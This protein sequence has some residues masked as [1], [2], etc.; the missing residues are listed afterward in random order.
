[1]Q[2]TTRS[3]RQ[4]TPQ[5][6]ATIKETPEL[7]SDRGRQR[8][9]STPQADDTNTTMTNMGGV[10]RSRRP[11]RRSTPSTKPSPLSPNSSRNKTML[12]DSQKIHIGFQHH[13]P[14][15]KPTS[16]V[17]HLNSHS[18]RKRTRKSTDYTE[19]PKKEKK[20]SY[21]F[22]ACNFSG[23]PPYPNKPYMHKNHGDWAVPQRLAYMVPNQGNIPKKNKPNSQKKKLYYELPCFLPSDQV[24][25]AL[26]DQ[27]PRGATKK[28]HTNKTQVLYTPGGKKPNPI[29][30]TCTKHK[31]ETRKP[32]NNYTPNSP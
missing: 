27:R 24:G 18:T 2:K 9:R 31:E 12:N 16:H 1:M 32:K 20:R 23:V 15:S 7:S 6:P 25:N 4:H 13:I 29:P 10:L 26:T 28:R 30:P 22:L 8:K 5:R 21:I 19:K 17:K 14:M 3:N 11:N